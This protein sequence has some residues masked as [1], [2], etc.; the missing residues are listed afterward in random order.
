M[1]RTKDTRNGEVETTPQE[2]ANELAPLLGRVVRR[3]SVSGAAVVVGELIGITRDGGIPLVS[4]RDQPGAAALES[5][6]TI[7]LHKAHVGKPVVLVFEDGDP[8]RPIII[9]MIRGEQQW[10]SHSRVDVES[11]GER[12]VVTAKQELVLRCG[13]ASITLTQ[14]GKILLRGTYLSTHA[15]GVNRIKGGSVQIN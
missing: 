9:G 6:S 11:D 8:T 13:E 7:D 12:V 5:R 4:Y 14:D 15:S 2:P 1:K 10:S 3:G